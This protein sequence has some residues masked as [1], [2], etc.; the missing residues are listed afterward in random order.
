[1]S[2]FKRLSTTLVARIDALVG[3][4]ENHD[5]VAEAAITETRRAVA[6]AKVRLTAFQ[7]EEEKL[8]A[9]LATQRRAEAAWTERARQSA[10]D[11]AKALA[12][13]RRRRECARQIASL[14]EALQTHR[15]AEQ[16]MAADIR[17]AEER[18]GQLTRQRNLMRTRQ[19]AA[20]ALHT[21]ADAAGPAGLDLEKTF[22]RWEASL[23]E[24]EMALGTGP[25]VDPLER[26]F[27]DAEEDE[28][29]RA[30]LARLTGER[31]NGNEQ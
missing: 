9:D 1:M 29:L 6:Q 30:E 20:R 25:A 4:V 27:A 8:E 13:L 17:S 23:L 3:Q 22:E 10:G 15:T 28:A 24:Q 2:L 5:A 18:L 21:T 16:R 12:C 19:S 7:R 14:E 31:E 26:D 11:D